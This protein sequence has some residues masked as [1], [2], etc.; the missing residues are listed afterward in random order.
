VTRG[1][2]GVVLIVVGTGSIQAE[3]RSSPIRATP[4]AVTEPPAARFPPCSRW[5]RRSTSRST[6]MSPGW[7]RVTIT[8]REIGVAI[9]SVAPPTR[10]ACPT[11][12]SSP[13]LHPALAALH[14]A[15][16]TGK[17]TVSGRHAA[18]HGSS[19]GSSHRA[20]RALQVALT[21]PGLLSQP[22]HH[23][24]YLKIADAESLRHGSAGSTPSSNAI[25]PGICPRRGQP[26]AASRTGA[27]PTG[28]RVSG[29]YTNRDDR[30]HDP[31]ACA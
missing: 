13:G 16:S 2:A 4:A 7:A 26:A 23:R 1:R 27:A 3:V 17:L 22:T 28:R 21:A 14:L 5:M 24:A 19:S 15:G 25:A 30:A 8:H 31:A 10:T 9:A 12:A 20:S 29:G 6:S 11:S 18:L